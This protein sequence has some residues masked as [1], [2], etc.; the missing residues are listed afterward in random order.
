MCIAGCL[1]S[2]PGFYPLDDRGVFPQWQRELS[3]CILGDQPWP[4]IENQCSRSRTLSYVSP[5]NSINLTIPGCLLTFS[6]L[7]YCP[8]CHKLA[9]WGQ[10]GFMHCSWLLWSLCFWNSLIHYGIDFLKSLGHSTCRMSPFWICH[11]ASSCCHLTVSPP[12][13]FPV[14]WTAGQDTMIGSLNVCGK[15]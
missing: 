9:S 3:S 1:A 12:S 14:N 4:R 10:C 7:S 2:I 8:T 11:I 15:N 13:V 5:V 6:P